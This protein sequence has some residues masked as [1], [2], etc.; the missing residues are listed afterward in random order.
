AAN[1]NE[2]EKDNTEHIGFIA[3]GILSGVLAVALV[4]SISIHINRQHC[5]KCRVDNEDDPYTHNRPENRDMTPP[6]YDAVV[7]PQTTQ[8]YENIRDPSPVQPV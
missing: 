7:L 5:V 6:V 3:V 2:S 4:I 8:T 1:V